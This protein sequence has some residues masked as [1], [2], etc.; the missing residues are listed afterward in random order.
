MDWFLYGRDLHYERVRNILS[1]LS[2]FDK[3]EPVHWF[4]L[5]RETKRFFPDIASEIQ[6]CIQ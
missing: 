4:I 2:T 1:N 3:M 5:E 6:W